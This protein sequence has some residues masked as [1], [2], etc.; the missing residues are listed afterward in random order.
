MMFIRTMVWIGPPSGENGR[1]VCRC[2]FI[3]L[4]GG[5]IWSIFFFSA[6]S[7]P[8]CLRP[9]VLISCLRM[10]CLCLGYSYELFYC[11]EMSNVAMERSTDGARQKKP[12]SG[13]YCGAK[14]FGC[15]LKVKN[16]E[17]PSFIKILT[18]LVR[19]VKGKRFVVCR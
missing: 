4:P 1:R 12:Q 19:Y 8:Q 18:I 15:F 6:I 9:F 16:E 3:F 14:G 11:S 2:N 7:S 10:P 5:R 17:V 13:G